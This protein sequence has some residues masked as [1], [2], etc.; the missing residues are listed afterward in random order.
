[1]GN[2]KK[3]HGTNNFRFTF[4]NLVEFKFKYDYT[5]KI[6]IQPLF[7]VFLMWISS[8]CVEGLIALFVS[9]HS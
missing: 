9:L 7:V 1:M 8:K 3:P 2:S 6:T 4:F 5:C